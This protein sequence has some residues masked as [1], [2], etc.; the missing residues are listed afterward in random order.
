MNAL[1]P[2]TAV[3]SLASKA[4]SKWLGAAGCRA[5]SNAHFS[6]RDVEAAQAE[7]DD[8][9]GAEHAP[10]DNGRPSLEGPAARGSNVADTP[11]E[12]LG[13]MPA[14]QFADQKRA[15]F[16]GLADSESIAGGAPSSSG[17]SHVSSDG[18]AAMVDVSQV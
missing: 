9:F 11:G 14:G 1:R 16:E 10:L 8:F 2:L 6:A 18:S 17:L 4:G 12:P 15:I 13:G 7:L 5:L 3:V